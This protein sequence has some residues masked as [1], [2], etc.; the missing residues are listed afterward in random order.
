MRR[1]AQRS[2][3]HKCSRHLLYS[4]EIE[5]F[6]CA[7]S[8]TTDPFS[9][10]TAPEASER[11]SCRVRVRELAVMRFVAMM[12]FCTS[13]GATSVTR[14]HSA[15]GICGNGFYQSCFDLGMGVRCK[16]WTSTSHL[17]K[18]PNSRA[19]RAHRASIQ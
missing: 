9:R 4:P 7:R 3:D 14:D 2:A 18:K 19:S 5:Y 8:N 15:C 12:R 16:R 17:N 6:D 11:K 1:N 13:A 10:T